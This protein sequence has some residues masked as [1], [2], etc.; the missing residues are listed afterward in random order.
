MG[1]SVRLPIL[2]SLQQNMHAAQHDPS[3][4]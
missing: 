2:T 3:S 4:V 1:I